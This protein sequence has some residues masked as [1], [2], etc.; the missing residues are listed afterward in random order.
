M[1]IDAQAVEVTKLSLLLKVLEGEA[2]EL[3]GKTQD[4]YRVLPDLGNNIKCGNSLIG[5]DFYQQPNLPAFDDEARIKINAFDWAH[6]FKPAMSAG[7][8]DA[9]IGNPPYLAGR[10]WE[11]E[12]HE[13]RSYF[14]SHYSCFTDQYDLYALFIQQSVELVR[15]SGYYGVITP[16]T[17]LNN[18]HYLSL[19][20]WLTQ[21]ASISSLS[22]YR[23]VRVFKDAT[24]LPIIFVARKEI[25]GDENKT[26]EIRSFH[27]ETEFIEHRSSVAIWRQFPNVVFNLLL[28]AEDIPAIRKIESKS[29]PLGSLAAVRFGV[30]VYQKGKGRPKQTGHEA[31]EKIFEASRK[32]SA[33]YLPYLW[34]G[35]VTPWKVQRAGTWLKYGEHLAEPRTIDLFTGSRVLVRRIVGT[36]LVLAPV[37]ETLVADQLLHTVKPHGDETNANFLAAILQSRVVAYYFRKRFNR[38]EKTFPEIRVAELAALPI[39][40]IDPK[41]KSDRAQHDALVALVERML[42]LHTD[43]AAAKSPDA[44]TH[45]ARDIAATDRAIDAL[46]Y[47]LYGL[48]AEEIALVEQANAPPAAKTE[49]AA[50]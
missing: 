22:D 12:L 44:Q 30:K 14:R 34:G 35:H 23:N 43:L 32:L 50:P 20:E 15:T 38:T 8:F 45:L 5:S 4:F 49:S 2:R 37:S 1:D 18:E 27:K 29:M 25:A 13:Q 11:A 31:A 9:V 36:R 19:R 28:T 26:I 10:E 16:N 46:V 40:V 3:R 6:E 39:R 48:S 42:K 41:K 33:E 7:G 24:V 17:W 47:Q 21:S